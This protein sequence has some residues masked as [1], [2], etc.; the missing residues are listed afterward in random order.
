MPLVL[1]LNNFDTI[2]ESLQTDKILV[3][4]IDIFNTE[5]KEMLDQLIIKN[6]SED[7]LSII[8]SC[9]CGELKGTYYVGDVCSHCGTTVTSSVDDNISFLLWLQAPQEVEYFISPIILSI[10]LNRYKITKPNV[11]LIKYIMLPN[12]VID[13]KQQKK[14]LGMLEKLDFLLQTN[15]I[16]RGYNSFVQNFFKIVQILD[17]EFVKEKVTEKA[18]FQEFLANNKD[19]IFSRYLPFPNKIMFAMDS[20]ELG[21]FIDKSLLNPINVIRRV[22]GIDLYTKPSH[23]KQTKVA[24]SLIDLAEF[25]QGYMKSTFFSK[26]GLIRQHISSTRSHFTGRAVITSIPGPHDYDE[27]WLPW[28]LSCSLLREHILNRLYARNY[29]YKQA[30]NFLVFHNKIYHPVLDEIFKEIITAAG[31]GIT[32]SI[33]VQQP[34]G[35]IADFIRMEN[36]GIKAFLNRNPSLHRGSIQTVRITRV[37]TDLDDNTFSMSY[38]IGPSFNADYDGDE[39]NLTLPMTEKV[40]RHMDNFEPH[41]NLLSLSGPNDFTSNIKFP[42]TIVSTLANWMNS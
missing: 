11:P 10:L 24:K 4:T 40:Y 16:K 22:T 3:N 8:P 25:Y 34:D 41:H 12:Y 32:G 31:N 37:K 9:H 1:R 21:K 14:N 30:I 19:K 5:T 2:Y 28:S 20:N 26:P 7:N 42:K 38:L 15:G 27:L 17:Q 36:G 29:S 23:I 33:P 18:A 13:K 39:L 6:Y 35:T